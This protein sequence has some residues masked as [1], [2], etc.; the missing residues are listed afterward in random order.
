[1]HDPAPPLRPP[2]DGAGHVPGSDAGAEALTE[3]GRESIR[4]GL[5]FL[6]TTIDEHGA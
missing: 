3:A 4:R 6:E 2:G 5:D 1:M